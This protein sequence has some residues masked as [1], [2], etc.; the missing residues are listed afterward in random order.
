MQPERGPPASSTT[1]EE[2]GTAASPD[3]GL[4]RLAG[5]GR[6]EDAKALALVMSTG[7]ERADLAYDVV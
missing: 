2:I 3:A 7:G 4:Y 1:C 5:R 6:G